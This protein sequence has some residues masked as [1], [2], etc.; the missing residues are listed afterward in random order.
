MRHDNTVTYHSSPLQLGA[1]P[2]EWLR[3]HVREWD[4]E[5][6]QHVHVSGR[7]HRPHRRLLLWLS[8]S[9]ADQVLLIASVPNRGANHNRDSHH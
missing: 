2:L 6:H 5:S 3:W 4:A 1:Q 9:C 8:P 7:L